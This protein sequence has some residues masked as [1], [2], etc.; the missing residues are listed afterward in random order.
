VSRRIQPLS[1]LLLG[2]DLAIVPT[3]LGIAAWLRSVVPFGRGGALDEAAVSLPWLMYLLAAV[4]WVVCLSL[5]EAYSPQ[6]ILRWYNEAFRVIYG[7]MLA[8]FVMAGVLYLGFREMSRLQ[9]VYFLLVNTA[10]LLGVRGLLRGYFILVGRARPGWRNRIL[11]VGAGELGGRVAQVLRDQSRWGF[12]PVGYLD[13]DPSKAQVDFEGLSV[14]GQ[15]DSLSR[16]VA[17]RAIDEVWVALPPSA[18]DRVASIVTELERRPVRIKIIPDYFSLALVQAKPEVIGGMPVIG[19]REPM[20][21]GWPR[22]TKRIFDLVAGSALTLVLAPVLAVVALLI[23]LEGPGPA[24][25]RQKRVGENGR[26]FDMLK[27]RSMVPEAE[28]LAPAVATHQADGTLVHKR[29][30]DPRVTPLG[31]LLRRYSLDELPQLFNVLKGEM[32]LV[33]PRPEQPWLVDMYQPWQRKRFAV[34]QGI[35]GWWQINGRSDKP[36]HMNTDDD[37]YYVFNYSLWLDILILLRTPLVV[38]QG[39]GAF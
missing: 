22:V 21:E 18:H 31:R 39:K 38:L 14:L 16:V 35:T 11:I 26:L 6:A 32:S 27:F 4:C 9:F 25:I 36:M 24:L 5:S 3:G 28:A 20:I 13:D 19:L 17:E 23:R 37:L 33:G 34:P 12:S 10:L 15:I 1:L 8:T 30:D 29:K 2:L 7:S